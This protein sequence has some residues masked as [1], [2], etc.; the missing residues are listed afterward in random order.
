VAAIVP[1]LA[2]CRIDTPERSLHPV[3]VRLLDDFGERDNMLQA[4]VRNMYD[5]TWWGSVTNYFTLYREPLRTPDC[6][7]NRRIRYHPDQTRSGLRE[8]PSFPQ[9]RESIA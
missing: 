9:K 5:F 1:I 7:I 2:T 6:C 8:N 4:V 3:V